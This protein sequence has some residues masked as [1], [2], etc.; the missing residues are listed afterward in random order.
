MVGLILG[1]V[2]TDKDAII[3]VF[4]RMI[5]NVRREDMA[6][7][8][9]AAVTKM[10]R[11]CQAIF[12]A[13][14]NYIGRGCVNDNYAIQPILDRLAG[15]QQLN[16]A[17]PGL[18]NLLA[19]IQSSRYAGTICD[20]IGVAYAADRDISFNVLGVEREEPA[21]IRRKNH[22]LQCWRR[23]RDETRG[24]SKDIVYHFEDGREPDENE[25]EYPFGVKDPRPPGRQSAS[26]SGSYAPPPEPKPQPK[27][28]PKAPAKSNLNAV[29]PPPPVM[30][31]EDSL[32]ADEDESLTL[33]TNEWTYPNI[34]LAGRK[35]K[36]FRKRHLG[37]S[38]REVVILLC[39]N[40]AATE[41][42]CG[43]YDK[44]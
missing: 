7:N 15:A 5:R 18:Q 23:W 2:A 3:P 29:N 32:S 26:A 20:Y 21:E 30:F 39:T 19:A 17:G 10:R 14:D 31:S 28:R 11:I 40:Q 9:E 41:D 35:M 36:S 37:S 27:A 13:A 16:N 12:V 1:E 22:N 8:L 34:N 42:P 44:L 33:S 24:T 43:A 38:D 6:L 4:K 25:V